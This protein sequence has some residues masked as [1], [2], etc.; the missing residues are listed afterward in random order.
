VLV[1]AWVC[2]CTGYYDA[3]WLSL[4]CAPILQRCQYSPAIRNRHLFLFRLASFAAHLLCG[5]GVSLKCLAAGTTSTRFRVWSLRASTGFG[6]VSIGFSPFGYGGSSSQSGQ[7]AHLL[8]GKT[9][10]PPDGFKDSCFLHQSGYVG[11]HFTFI[12][13]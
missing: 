12:A 7:L 13:A 6:V 8:N 10:V 2:I 3:L 1:V 4:P 9:A 11:L 5:T